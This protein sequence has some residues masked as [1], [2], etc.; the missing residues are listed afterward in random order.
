MLGHTHRHT[1]TSISWEQRLWNNSRNKQSCD[2]E[3]TAETTMIPF[4]TIASLTSASLPRQSPLWPLT[5]SPWRQVYPE[6][7]SFW[8][9][10]ESSWSRTG[11]THTSC[12]SWN[13]LQSWPQPGRH[14]INLECSGQRSEVREQMESS[15]FLV[16]QTLWAPLAHKLNAS[17]IRSVVAAATNTQSSHP[18]KL[19]A[20]LLLGPRT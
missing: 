20:S 18:L 12:S 6:M 9:R 15:I 17:F 19:F 7:V 10:V 13:S 8:R 2:P 3:M 16:V 5:W 4:G 11:R 1:H 14:E